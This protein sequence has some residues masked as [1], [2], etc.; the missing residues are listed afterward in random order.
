MKS[1]HVNVV[2]DLVASEGEFASFFVNDPGGNR[3]EISW[4]NE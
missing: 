4:H 3:I 1:G 2:R